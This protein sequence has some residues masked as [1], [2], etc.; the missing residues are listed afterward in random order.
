MKNEFI[1][2]SVEGMTGYVPGEQPKGGDIIKLNT[3]EN[4]YPPSPKVAEALAGIDVDSLRKYPDPVSSELRE[5][6][7][8]MHGCGVENVFA[9][10]GSDEILALCTRAFVEN[11]GSVGYFDPSY[12]LYPI[13]SDIRD[14]KKVTVDLDRDFGWKCPAADLCSL[15]FLTNPNAPTSMLFPKADVE[16]FCRE[17]QGVVLVDEAYVDFSSENCMD[18]ALKY[19]NVLVMRTLSKSFSLAGLRVGY[20]VGDA[21]LIGALMKIKDSYN[22]DAL[23]QV[24]A[25]A[26]LNDVEYMRVNSARIIATREMLSDSL[27]DMEFAVCPSESNF[28][29]VRP[30]ECIAASDLFDKLKQ[31]GILVRYF[32]DEGINEYIRITVGTDDE[33]AALLRAVRR[34]I[35]S[36]E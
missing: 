31:S 28:L 5:R 32:S 2:E 18:L 17:F 35:E 21:D 20:V 11:D 14:I 23:A 13:L 3:N 25:L 8:E 10:N 36:G 6:I 33:V 22:L 26:A 7:A 29:W 1:R 27:K 15:F 9:G 34:I 30:P 24:L 4:P 16:S 12:S 19:K